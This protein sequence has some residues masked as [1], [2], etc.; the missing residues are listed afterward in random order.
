ML[1]NLKTKILTATTSLLIA[2]GMVL[3][4]LPAM[5]NPQ[6]PATDKGYASQ[7]DETS[8]TLNATA[9]SKVKFTDV[10]SNLVFYKEINQLADY[11]V[12]KGWKMKNGTYQYRPFD[13]VKR[14]AMIVFIYRAMGSPSYTPPKK[15]PFTD[16][17]TKHV[18]YKEI[19]W[20]YSEGIAEGWKMK[21]GTRQFRPFE[22]VKRDAM[23]AFLMRASGQKAPAAKKSFADVNTNQPHAAAMTWMKETGIS[24][25]W[26]N[27]SKLPNYQP[28]SNTKRD[29]MA[30]F[31]IRW[32]DKTP[33]SA[34]TVRHATVK[35][36]RDW[37]KSLPTVCQNIEMKN[38]QNINKYKNYA[39]FRATVTYDTDGSMYYSLYIDGT[40]SP[41]HPASVA[42]M[43]HE[44][45]HVLAGVYVNKKSWNDLDVLLDKGWSRSDSMRTEKVADCI[46]DQLGAV[47]ESDSYTVGYGTKCSTAQKNVAKTL[48]NFSVR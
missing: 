21:D 3:S 1:K 11:G 2:G 32:L 28:Y 5:A 43:K 38:F 29:A 19:A 46:S 30:T 17:S 10:S 16:V 44:C 6:E 18:F 31:I 23:A 42:L 24:T 14:D 25:G 35:E 27:G 13:D 20:A 22:P 47:R 48:V 40:I 4:P 39:S 41:D 8:T 7:T 33:P 15:S 45:G 34:T 9:N 36:H 37:T 12:T 26:K